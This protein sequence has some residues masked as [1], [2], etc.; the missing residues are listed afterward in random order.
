MGGNGGNTVVMF[1][2]LDAV[3]VVT[4]TNYNTK[5]CTSRPTG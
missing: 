1:R 3:V 4:R 5:A 2:E